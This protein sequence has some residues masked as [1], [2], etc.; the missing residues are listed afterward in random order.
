MK[1]NLLYK[2]FVA[3]IA[4]MIVFSAVYWV[5]A[6]EINPEEM[7]ANAVMLLD[8]DTG[9]VLYEKNPDMQVAPASTTKLLTAVVVLEH[10]QLT[11]EITVG[12]EVSVSGSLMGLKPGQ[13]VTVETLLYGMFLCSGNDA[14]VALAVKIAGS[15]DNFAA[16][17]NQKAK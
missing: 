11:D 7:T 8:Q 10:L 17:M 4:F 2:I 14:A 1:R 12:G 5:F 13:T 16:M 3:L 9:A 6:E 15:T